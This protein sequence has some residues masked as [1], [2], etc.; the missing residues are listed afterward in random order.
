MNLYNLY[1]LSEAILKNDYYSFF[2]SFLWGIIGVIF[3]PC[4]IAS[5]PLIIAF[6][7]GFSENK[8]I[9]NA[10]WYSLL[11]SIALFL[12]ILFLGLISSLF[13]RI[14]INLG[15]ILKYIVG[16]IL[17]IVSLHLFG[18]LNFYFLNFE[19][20]QTNKKGAVGAFL[21]GLTY[22]LISS[23]CT[24]GFL[25]PI[26]AIITLEKNFMRGIILII[27]FGIGQC[28]PILI[29]GSLTSFAKKI[30]SSNNLQKTGNI[31]KKF[32]AVIFIIIAIYLIFLY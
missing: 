20:I 4:H 9:K 8:K 10:F 21:L 17:I 19:K 14:L 28:I 15:N 25:A 27:F 24:F 7:A 26:L 18:I 3:S 31:F 30:S 29:A 1:L 12:S 23:P 2:A 11:F 32:A 6:I 16:I 5:I 13:G 22:G